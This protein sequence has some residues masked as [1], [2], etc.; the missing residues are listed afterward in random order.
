MDLKDFLKRIVYRGVRRSRGTNRRL[1]LLRTSDSGR[2]LT[3]LD[4]EIKAGAG[5]AQGVAMA[6]GTLVEG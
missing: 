2:L 3:I 5:E 6:G 4:L 1:E